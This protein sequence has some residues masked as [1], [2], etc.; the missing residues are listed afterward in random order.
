[1]VKS[2][3]TSAAELP[4]ASAPDVVPAYWDEACRHLAKRDRVLKKLI[5]RFGEACLRSRG[6]AFTTLARS[7]VGQQI[8]VKAAQSVW[9]RFA[10]AVG[11]APARLKPAAVQ[12]LPVPQMRAAGLSG[13]KTEYLL[14]LARHFAVEVGATGQPSAG[15][16]EQEGVAEPLGFHRLA[17]ARHAGAVFDD[18][19]LLAEHAVEQRALAHVGAADDDDYRQV[20]FDDDRARAH[21]RTS[22]PVSSASRSARP[23]VA[24]TSTARGRSVTVSPSR[25]RPSDRQTSGNR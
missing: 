21:R 8:S 17:V 12:A 10:L 3:A 16:D 18:R 19:H 24:T 2:A 5:P 20:G 11:G 15:V 14:D 9:D 22:L 13:R 25:K 1:M 6:D 7:I 23:S 4:A